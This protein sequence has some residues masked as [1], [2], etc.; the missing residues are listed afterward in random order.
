MAK[1]RVLKTFQDIHTKEVYNK[2][3]EI[4]MNVERAKEVASNLGDTFL[5]RLDEPKTKAKKD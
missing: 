3:K 2:N 5:K 1:F 4:E